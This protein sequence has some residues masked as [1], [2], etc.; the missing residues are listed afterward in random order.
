MSCRGTRGVGVETVTWGCWARL[1]GS[2][3]CEKGAKWVLWAADGH[4][5]RTS[6]FDAVQT[7]CLWIIAAHSFKRK[8]LLHAPLCTGKSV[9]WRR[10]LLL[11]PKLKEEEAV[12]N[13]VHHFRHPVHDSVIVDCS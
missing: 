2:G 3:R 12:A 11:T 4:T 9:A 8:G 13:T 5:K 6:A 10:G 1:E 7:A